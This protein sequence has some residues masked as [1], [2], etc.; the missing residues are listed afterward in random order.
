MRRRLQ[1]H[2]GERGAALVEMVLILPFLISLVMGTIEFGEGWQA[3][4]R[5]QAATRGAGRTGA[6][7]ATDRLTDY[8]MLQTLKAGLTKSNPAD[9]KRVVIYESDVTG[10]PSALCKAGTSVK[11][12]C[13]VYTGAQMATL[14][15]ANF[16]GTTSCLSNAPDVNWC[17]MDRV[18]TQA[19]AD[20]MGVWVEVFHPYTT[21]FFPGSGI[22][23]QQ[24]FVLRLEPKVGT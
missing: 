16:T 4:L 7:L 24:H 6:S 20:H 18:N 8:F 5:V 22:T 17:P 13:N 23:L 21:G 1:P 3:N 15:P 11:D 19:V 14:T 2:C 10:E 9:I 12:V